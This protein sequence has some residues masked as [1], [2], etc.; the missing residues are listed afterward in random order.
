HPYQRLKLY[1]EQFDTLSYFEL[2]L[3]II[4]SAKGELHA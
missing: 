1:K 4:G 3:A 2:K